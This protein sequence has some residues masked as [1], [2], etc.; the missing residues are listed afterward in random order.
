M[1][2]RDSY[3]SP[4]QSTFS[5]MMSSVD[6][7]KVE[8][9]L[10]EWQSAVRGAPAEDELVVIDGKIPKHSGGKNVVTAITS[11]SERAP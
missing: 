9:V 5:R 6:I 8:A 1:C 4:D 10:I 11:P 7:D 3:S 2:I